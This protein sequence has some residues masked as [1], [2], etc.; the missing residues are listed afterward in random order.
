[1]TR[2]KKKKNKPA[3][4]SGLQTH[5]SAGR[6]PKDAQQVQEVQPALVGP[7]DQTVEGQAPRLGPPGGRR[8]GQSPERPV[9]IALESHRLDENAEAAVQSCLLPLCLFH[10]CLPSEELNA[11]DVMDIELDFPD[12]S[13]SALPTDGALAARSHSQEVSLGLLFFPV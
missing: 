2:Q 11:D 8:P 9:R 6:S 13:D 1:M 7:A 3:S 5:A 10:V 4:P 12:L